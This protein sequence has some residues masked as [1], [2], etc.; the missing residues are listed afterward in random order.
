MP[1][2]QSVP[3]LQAAPF[4]QSAN[5]AGSLTL[6][7]LLSLIPLI[8]MLG[9]LGGLRWK[10]HWAGLTALISSIL[11]AVL[12]YGMPLLMSVDS[13]FY[14]AAQGALLI[15]WLTFNCVWIYNLTVRSGHFNVL[16]RAFGAVSD[17]VRIQIVVIAFCFGALLEALAGGG[18][19]V[20]ICSVMLIALGVPP[21][22]AATLALI[23]DTAPVAFGGLG[24][25]IIALHTVTGLPGMIFSAMIGRDAAVM[26]VIVPFVLLFV[27]DGMRGLRQRWPVALAAGVPCAILQFLVSNYF[28]YQ[29]TDVFG[30]IGSVLA[31]V[32]LVRIWK[33]TGEM[34]TAT[35]L[36][37]ARTADVPVAV[38]ADGGSSTGTSS[39]TG[40][41]GGET[42]AGTDA[43]VRDSPSEIVRAFAPY[44]MI[45]V[46]FALAQVGPIQ[47]VLN[48]IGAT[49]HWPGLSVVSPAG[50]A[51]STAY[52]FNF[53]SANGTLLL[54]AG[55]LALPLLR[56]G[57]REAVVVYGQTMAQ[58]GWAIFA[59]LCVFG[60]SYVMN[61]SG[62]I[63]VLGT[64]LAGTGSFFPFLAPVVGWFG[65]T[66]TGTDA[67]SNTLFGVLQTTAASK[68]HVNQLLLT[69]GGSAGGVMA[70]M[71]SPQSLAV[72]TAAVRLVGREGD[73]FRR[74]FWWSMILLLATCVMVYLQSTPV[75]GWMVPNP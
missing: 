7:A 70:K 43:D 56:V 44:G 50:K 28:S 60:L 51:V 15:L 52:Q 53:G 26:S 47:K 57:L 22:K 18:G 24:T 36:R 16:R 5:P 46:V 74:V 73:L 68:L 13:A 29:L 34:V 67:G 42:D 12:G 61:L 65:V 39:S 66:I 40:G 48:A 37:G 2:L 64:W 58:F 41:G 4:Q 6:S 71:V 49:F 72:G 54:I 30:S 23:A 32:L 33:P 20:A 45:I 9:L 17:D 55:L 63:T 27:A 38:G 69:G 35:T 19:P 25:P 59:I 3:L 75:L 8:V 21:L 10:A 1:L 11:V 62:Q 14:G 31:V